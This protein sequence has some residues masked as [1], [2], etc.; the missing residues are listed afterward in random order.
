MEASLSPEVI[1]MW[2]G[3]SITNSMLSTVLVS[4]FMLF[5]AWFL[6]KVL[7]RIPGRVQ[8]GIEL[9]Y[10]WLLDTTETIVGNKKAARE[11]FPYVITIFFFILISNWSELLPGLNTISIHVLTNGKDVLVPLFRVPTTDLNM[12]LVMALISM[13]YVEYLGLKYAGPKNYIGHFINFHG[14]IDFFVGLLELIGEFT[15]IISF[16]FRLFGN[17]FAGDVLLIVMFYLNM[18]LFPFLPIIPLPFFFLELFVGLVQAFVFSFLTIIF[19]SLAVATH[20][21]EE[22][23]QEAEPKEQKL[24]LLTTIN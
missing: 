13:G 22:H 3:L 9:I 5:G 6:R 17:M 20:H 11:V 24:P 19:V 14:P 2:H 18:K 16:T 23:P 21:P 4:L 8:V 15:R 1:F 10:D 12:V 7:S